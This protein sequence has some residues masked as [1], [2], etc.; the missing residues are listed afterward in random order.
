MSDVRIPFAIRK[1][2]HKFV[3]VSD[4]ER[5]LKGTDLFKRAKKIGSLSFISTL[6]SCSMYIQ[7]IYDRFRMGQIESNFK[8]KE[9][10]CYF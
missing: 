8:Q 4:V 6:T 5:E 10:W 2:D 7:C 9:T 1:S 3:E